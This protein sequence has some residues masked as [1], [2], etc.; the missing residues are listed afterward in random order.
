MKKAVLLLLPM[1]LSLSSC[2]KERDEQL[3]KK[4]ESIE[5]SVKYSAKTDPIYKM[6]PTENMWNFL[7]LDTRNGKISIVQ[8]SVS[9]NDQQFEYTLSD[10]AQVDNKM[11]G[12]F[13]LIPTKNI[14]NFIMLDQISGQSYQVQWSFDADKRFVIPI[15]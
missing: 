11:P 8:F 2:N 6:Y 13:T 7:K 10:V 15:N 14:Y 3:M 1:M 4:I 12:R 5:S 9:D